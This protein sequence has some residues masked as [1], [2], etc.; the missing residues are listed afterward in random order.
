MK[1]LPAE[2]EQQ[3]AI[4]L[5]WPHEDSDWASNLE[6]VEDVYATIATHIARHE[7]VLIVCRDGRHQA[8][9][10]AR[11]EAERTGR[12]QIVFARVPGNDTWIRD[13]G[14]I[15]VM[16][17]QAHVLLDFGFNGWG[18]KY[19]HRLD[20]LLTQRLCEQGAFGATPREAVDFVLEGG[21]IECDGSG[22]LMT[23]RRCLL[24]P[25][26]NPGWDEADITGLL[27]SCFGVRRVIWLEHGLILG[28]DT[29]GHIDMLARFCDERTIAY[30]ACGDSGD[31]HYPALRA[32]ARELEALTTE[33]GEPYRL[34]PLPLPAPIMTPSGERLPA[35]YANFLII[36][37]AV[38]VPTY[39]DPADEIALSRLAPCFP[40][41]AIIGIPCRPLIQQHGSLHCVTMQLPAGVLPDT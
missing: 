28:D 22:T 20:R 29:D 8:M 10:K 30:S 6:E 9:V 14:P 39:G 7:K 16:E 24:A 36:N 3:D 15:T 19:P 2:W 33:A 35:S 11:L 21:S 40:G 4:I 26:R 18:G 27:A 38:L 25:S 32:M 34:V 13:T 31:A 41:R 5:V 23:T 1:R 17:D 37:D 12:S